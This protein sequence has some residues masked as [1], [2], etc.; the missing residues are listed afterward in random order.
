MT[1]IDY[2]IFGKRKKHMAYLEMVRINNGGSDQIQSEKTTGTETERVIPEPNGAYRWLVDGFDNIS[3]VSHPLDE[4]VFC[5]RSIISRRPNCTVAL[6]MN[7]YHAHLIQVLPIFQ[8]DEKSPTDPA[9]LATKTK[10]S[11][12]LRQHENVKNAM[13][14]R[15]QM[16]GLEMALGFDKWKPELKASLFLCLHYLEK[17]YRLPVPEI[18]RIYDAETARFIYASHV[19]MSLW[20]DANDKV[21]W[22]LSS[23]SDQ[24]VSLIMDSS[25]IF[26]QIGENSYSFS[27]TANGNYLG[28]Y[29]DIEPQL[30]FEIAINVIGNTRTQLDAICKLAPWYSRLRHASGGDDRTMLLT[31]NYMSDNRFTTGCTTT[32]FLW[33]GMLRRLNIP[34][35]VK[36]YVLPDKDDIQGHHGVFMPIVQR[37]LV[38]ADDLMLPSRERYIWEQVFWPDDDVTPWRGELAEV[39]LKYAEAIDVKYGHR[40]RILFAAGDRNVYMQVNFRSYFLR[41]IIYSTVLEEMW[42]KANLHLRREMA[43]ELMSE[44]SPDLQDIFRQAMQEKASEWGI[45]IPM[46]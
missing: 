7:D 40:R 42:K 17:G 5:P 29:L 3:S 24:D 21:P 12:Y 32:S 39:N 6:E 34:A 8:G 33:A 14:W 20:V 10:Y 36:I 22:K 35:Q 44:L 1:I 25:H 11:R 41:E 15:D 46:P 13:I 45:E 19:A 43:E 27:E 26:Y 37:H 16:S 4:P 28:F 23:F 2:R 38:H 9:F 18:Q 30:N 31:T